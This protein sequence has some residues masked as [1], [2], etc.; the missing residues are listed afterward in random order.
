MHAL[1]RA[2]D[3]EL[4]VRSRRMACVLDPALLLSAPQALLL[5]RQLASVV[6]IWLC[7][8]LWRLLDASEFFQRSPDRLAHWLGLPDDIP[9]ERVGQALDL[10]GR[11]RASHDLTA[12]GMYWVGLHQTESFLPEQG[13]RDLPQ[14][15]EQLLVRWLSPDEPEAD[16]IDDAE[17]RPSLEAALEC[18]ALAVA[19]QSAPILTLAST[20]ASAGAPRLAQ[21]L[22]RRGLPS[23]VWPSGWEQAR[24]AEQQRW[25]QLLMQAGATATVATGM[26]LSVV[27]IVAPQAQFLLPQQE[28]GTDAWL[29]DRFGDAWPD[30]AG[31]DAAP[32]DDISGWWTQAQALWHNV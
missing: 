2:T 3:M 17:H 8:A 13:P 10:C 19:L 27:H 26:Q 1:T 9:A 29:D 11:W 7:P 20:Q 28:P 14:R 32:G 22:S 4:S 25:W 16:T 18:A 21:A 23:Q 12:L 24:Q 30:E 5:A 15:F 6:D 31:P